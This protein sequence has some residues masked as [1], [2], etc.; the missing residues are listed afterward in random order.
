VVRFGKPEYESIATYKLAGAFFA[1]PITLA[2][3]TY[4][5]WRWAG[6]AAALA[7]ALLAP[8]LGFATIVWHAAWKRFGEDVRVFTRVLFRRKTAARLAEMR[9]HL[10]GEFDA[11]DAEIDGDLELA[12]PAS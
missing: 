8:L 11:I 3:Y 2:V 10:A 9:A 1:F 7:T 12:R 5:A 6:P 4:L